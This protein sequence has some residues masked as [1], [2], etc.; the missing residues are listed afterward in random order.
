MR[1]DAKE[2]LV[3]V[4]DYDEEFVTIRIGDENFLLPRGICPDVACVPGGSFFL[5]TQGVDPAEEEK[6]ID[7]LL[8][9]EQNT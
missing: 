7:S 8:G 4:I 6:Q 1:P 2:C 5:L 3:E 9:T